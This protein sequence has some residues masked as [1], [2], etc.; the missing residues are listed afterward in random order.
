MTLG[1]LWS[2]PQSHGTAHPAAATIAINNARFA[3]DPSVAGPLGQL[4]E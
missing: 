2:G 4:E 3:I 1:I